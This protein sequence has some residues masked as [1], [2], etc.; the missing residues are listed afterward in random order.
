[1][2][3]LQSGSQVSLETLNHAILNI[4]TAIAVLEGADLIL[5]HG[6]EALFKVWGKD[7]SIIGKTLLDILPELK[8]QPFP[9]LLRQVMETGVGYEDKEAVAYVVKNGIRETIYFNYSYTAIPR[10]NGEGNAAVLVVA[11]DVTDLVLAKK[12]AEDRGA[13]LAYLNHAGEELALSLDTASA[14]DKISKFVVPQFADWFSINVVNG[15]KLD[16][17]FVYNEKQDY[18]NWAV[19]H[20]KRKPLRIDAPGIQSHIL[21]TGESSLVPLITPDLIRQSIE[22]PEQREILLGMDL[23]SSIVVP[24]KV[25][26]NIIGTINFIRTCSKKSYTEL[27]LSFAQDFAA[28]IAVSL[29]NARLHEQ[30][31][32]EIHQRISAEKKKDEFIGMASHELKTPLTSLS[33]YL[34]I[35]NRGDLPDTQKKFLEKAMYQSGK[36]TSLVNDML[37]LSK[38]AAG[39]LQFSFEKVDLKALIA[40]CIE[41]TELS[42]PSHKIAFSS[43]LVNVLVLADRHRMEQAILNLLSNAV[44]YSPGSD[45]VEVRLT[46]ANSFVKIAVTDWG[47]GIP[48]DKLPNL[49]ERFY[50]VNDTNPGISGLGIGLYITK[51]I[52][53]KHNGTIEVESEENKGTTFCLTLPAS[54]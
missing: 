9:E 21:K 3:K 51:E 18:V 7:A 6:N 38:I 22:D 28:R 17:L 29:E 33:G 37:D 5:T 1:M 52:I 25:G 47:I 45:K 40:E 34:Q 19:E 10:D 13:L 24:M 42:I 39:K 20:R 8:D 54:S 53:E 49:F 4:S 12:N 31:S 30:A 46:A 41:A 26:T 36:L 27:D 11:T 35:L 23:H 16:L 48:T 44:K 32:E 15:E 14:I 50:R 2:G 43:A